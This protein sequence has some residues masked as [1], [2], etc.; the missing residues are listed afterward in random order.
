MKAINACMCPWLIASFG[1]T[2]NFAEWDNCDAAIKML[3]HVIVTHVIG[4]Y[5]ESSFQVAVWGYTMEL[6]AFKHR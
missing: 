4:G 2:E 5:T 1:K 6:L 3:S